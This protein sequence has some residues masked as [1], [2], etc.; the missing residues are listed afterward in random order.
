MATEQTGEIGFLNI[1]ATPHPPGVYDRVIRS[2]AGKSVRF[3]GEQRAAITTPRAARGE[4]HLLEGRV[5]IWTEIDEDQPGVNKR[6]L[7]AV[8]LADMDFEVP[9]D[10]GFNGKTFVFV[11]NTT[12]HVLALETRNEYGQTLSPARGKRIFDLLLSPMVLGLDAESIEVTVIPEDDALDH[13]LALDRLD[14]V[15]ILVKRPNE[16]DITTKTNAVMAELMEQNAKSEERVLIRAARTDGIELSDE[17]MTRAEVAALNG[18]V[19]SSGIDEDGEAD[20]RST[21]EY[22]KIVRFVIDV[23]GSFITKVRDA[24]RTATARP[25]QR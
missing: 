4:P 10:L 11:F 22:P 9:A 12:A 20:K 3:Y 6:S 23:G 7:A 5:V 17:N 25:R 24:A 21:K 2:V 15:V 18:S 16:D 1:V 13:V 8:H 14:K 19:K